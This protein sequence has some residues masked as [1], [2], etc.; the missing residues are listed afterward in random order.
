MVEFYMHNMIL[1]DMKFWDHNSRLG[2]MQ[3]MELASWLTHE[4]ARAEEVNRVMTKEE[5]ELLYIRAELVSPKV[6]ISNHNIISINPKLAPWYMET[7][8]QAILHFEDT[9]RLLGIENLQACQR[10]W[11][12]LPHSLQIKEYQSLERSRNALERI[13]LYKRIMQRLNINWIELK[14]IPPLLLGLQE[15]IPSRRT[16]NS[17][18]LMSFLCFSTYN[19]KSLRS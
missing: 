13:P 7:Y 14:L 3:L 6:I 4:E 12:G 2:D 15:R 17:L 10:R 19:V 8:E 5:K 16:C 18:Q 9:F 11:H 1:I